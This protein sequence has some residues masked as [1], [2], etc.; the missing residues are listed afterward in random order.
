MEILNKIKVLAKI[1]IWAK[2]VKFRE[3]GTLVKCIMKSG[4]RICENAKIDFSQQM[5]EKAKSEI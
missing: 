4:D 2:T 3:I 5:R 1:V